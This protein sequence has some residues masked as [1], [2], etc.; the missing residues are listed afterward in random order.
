M[1]RFKVSKWLRSSEQPGGEPTRDRKKAS[2]EVRHR[3]H[4]Y[5]S[6]QSRG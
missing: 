2:R 5:W 6:R 4:R 3:E 1:E